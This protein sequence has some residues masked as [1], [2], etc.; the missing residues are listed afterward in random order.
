MTEYSH[1]VYAELS[2][3]TALNGYLNTFSPSP[4]F[5]VGA[6]QETYSAE[7]WLAAAEKTLGEADGLDNVALREIIE[8][9]KSLTGA[10]NYQQAR[11]VVQAGIREAEAQIRKLNE[12]QT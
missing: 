8:R 12:I 9:V 1:P 3:Y 2:I 5:M 11:L 4:N 6:P 7:D 10:G